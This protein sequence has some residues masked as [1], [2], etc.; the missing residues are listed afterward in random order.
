[1]RRWPVRW[2]VVAVGLVGTW[3]LGGM[4]DGALRSTWQATLQ[5]WAG[6]L[7]LMGP[8]AAVPLDG[9]RMGV[10]DGERPADDTALLEAAVQRPGVMVRVRADGRSWLVVAVRLRELA[11]GDDAGGRAVRSGRLGWA[12]VP[13]AWM[14]VERL[15]LWLFAIVFTLLPVV[16]G[17]VLWPSGGRAAGRRDAAH[18][19]A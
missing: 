12:A 11:A 10:W 6:R 16:V 9:W 13:A 19:R 15:K 2:G 4:L 17:V 14:D 5:A 18:V 7:A 1:M 8:Q 3:A